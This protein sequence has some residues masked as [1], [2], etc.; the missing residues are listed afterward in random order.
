MRLDEKRLRRVFQSAFESSRNLDAA[1]AAVARDV[2]GSLEAQLDHHRLENKRLKKALAYAGVG[3]RPGAAQE[4][5]LLELVAQEFRVPVAL[6][7][8]PTQMRGR[9]KGSSEASAIRRY[10][11]VLLE[12][13]GR[14]HRDIAA[15]VGV[16]GRTGVTHGIQRFEITAGPAERERLER[17]WS[18][19]SETTLGGAAIEIEVIDSIRVANGEA[20]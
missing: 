4:E 2:A 9:P 16:R 18:L 11:M 20:A 3:V 13:A 1:V 12:R 5:R 10:A 15:A 19:F 7:T 8:R 17:L 14:S 6:F